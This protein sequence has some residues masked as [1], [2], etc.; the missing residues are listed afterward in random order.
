MLVVV[1]LSV[2]LLNVAYT[3]YMLSV[4]MLCVI[5]MNVGTLSVVA[6]G[7]HLAYNAGNA[8]QGSNLV[9]HFINYEEKA[10]YNIDY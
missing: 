6:L 7:K 5:I 1:M 4:I 3:F 10:L 9:S 8:C 2:I